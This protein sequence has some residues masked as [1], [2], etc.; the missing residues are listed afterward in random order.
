MSAKP[1]PRGW[2][3]DRQLLLVLALMAG[4]LVMASRQLIVPYPETA[5]WYESA[6]FFPLL[7]LGLM[8]AGAGMQ[9]GA[10]RLIALEAGHGDIEDRLQS[11]GVDALDNVGTDPGLDCLAHHAG[12]VLV[13]KHDNGMG[14]I[15]TDQ[16]HLFQHIAAG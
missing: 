14:L 5:L 11:R 13:G 10:Q 7:A 4:N 6:A 3:W 8:A 16:H 2:S 12:V 1:N 9:L 15:T